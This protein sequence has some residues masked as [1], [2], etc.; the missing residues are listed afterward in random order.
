MA[1]VAISLQLGSRGLE[2]GRMAADALGYGFVTGDEMIAEAARRFNVSADDLLISD[3]RTPRFWERGRSERHR[4][5][6]Y[7]RAVLL[8]KLAAD[9]IVAAGRTI[10]H[11][12]PRCGSVLRVHVVSPFALRVKQIAAGEKL[13]IGA[14]EK[15]VRDYDREARERSQSLQSVDIEDSALYDL[16][17]NS[18]SHSFELHLAALTALVRRIDETAGAAERQPLRDAAV[19]AQVRAA[20]LAHPKIRDAQITV[21]CKEGVLVLNGAGLVPPWD[22]LVREIAGRIE[23]VARIEITAD[24]TPMLDR[25]G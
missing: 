8:E 24:E 18:A 7:L 19:A 5:L 23:G 11:Q 16:T 4:Y 20:L 13:E 1:V 6:A 17:V 25:A 14:A 22:A 3:L 9:R 2:F 12:P 10:A 21:N 15:R